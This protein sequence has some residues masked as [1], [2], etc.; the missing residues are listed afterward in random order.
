MELNLETVK[1][2]CRVDYDFEDDLIEL[3]M[4]ASQSVIKG[5]VNKKEEYSDFYIDNPTYT[6]A[7]IQLTKHY[8]DNR[9]A[10]T[11]FNLS[12]VPVGTLTL[13]QSLR[14]DYANWRAS[15]GA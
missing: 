10:T 4:S 12:K 9:S 3:Y 2:A 15:H 6:L 8:F 5:A 13:I 11:E 7:V 1:R 14:Q